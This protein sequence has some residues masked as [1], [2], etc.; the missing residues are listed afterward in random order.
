MTQRLSKRVNDGGY[1]ELYVP[2][3]GWVLEHRYVMEQEFGRPLTPD[4][5]VHHIGRKDDNRP[6][7]LFLCY[8]PEH[9][10]AH[11]SN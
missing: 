8:E 7:A 4:E 2:D 5:T 3:R 9:I 10:K 11:R 1:V 6:L